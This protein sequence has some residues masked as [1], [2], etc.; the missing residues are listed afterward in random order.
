[1]KTYPVKKIKKGTAIDWR[2]IPSAEISCYRWRD[3]EQFHAEARLVYVENTVFRCLLTCEQTDPWALCTKNGGKV[4]Q[5]SAL[6]F[7]VSF[8]PEGYINMEGN[9]LGVHLAE[10]GQGRADRKDI[11][12]VFFSESFRTEKGWGILYL[13]SFQNLQLF[14]PSLRSKQLVDGYTFR[15]NFYKT[16][17]RPES[18]IDHYGMWNEVISE[19]PDFH[20]PEYFG[21]FIINS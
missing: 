1:M 7:F 8:G 19:K 18:G 6:E 20:R 2:T 15:G 13:I 17:I 9:A 16:G 21:E 3:T 10:F 5:D 12:G 4:W 14:F 11:S